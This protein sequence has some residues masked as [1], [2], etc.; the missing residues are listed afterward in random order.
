[1]LVVTDD[2]FFWSRIEEAARKAG[3]E[4]ARV[5]GESAMEDAYRSG[6]VRRILA[7]LGARSVDVYDWARRWRST[8]H[9]PELVAFGHHTDRDAI[10]RAIEAGYGRF[11]PNSRLARELDSLLR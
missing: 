5:S 2:L 3:G 1:M 6:G 9:P 11:V 7:D 4:V 8:P 10:S